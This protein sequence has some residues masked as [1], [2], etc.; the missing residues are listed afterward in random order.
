MQEPKI[1]SV[2]KLNID[3]KKIEAISTSL[4]LTEAETLM[5]KL[6]RKSGYRQN[7]F[8]YAPDLSLIRDRKPAVGHKVEIVT[9]YY[10]KGVGII[11]RDHSKEESKLMVTL[12]PSSYCN[13]LSIM[14]KK[15]SLSTSGG[16]SPYLAV[17][18]LKRNG[19]RY[20]RFWYCRNGSL[21]AGSSIDYYVQVP[22]WE[23]NGIEG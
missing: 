21:T 2:S 13:P 6:D 20:Q 17:S 15:I 10:Q 3:F 22:F 7:H 5:L 19:N 4:N 18:G 14:E 8:I 9:G 1:F 23:Y 16:P 12:S 11:N